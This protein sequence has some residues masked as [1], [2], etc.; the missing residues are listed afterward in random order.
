MDDIDVAIS[1]LADAYGERG[2]EDRAVRNLGMGGVGATA[3]EPGI[4]GRRDAGDH[5]MRHRWEPATERAVPS[6]TTRRYCRLTTRDF[7]RVD[8]STNDRTPCGHQD[9]VGNGIR[10]HW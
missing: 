5:L 7:L 9:S 10:G 1:H 6:P 8:L 3:E 4:D 2:E